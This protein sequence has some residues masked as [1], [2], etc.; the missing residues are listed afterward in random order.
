[1]NPEAVLPRLNQ[2]CTSK[3]SQMPRNLRLWATDDRH[4]V[5]DA[6]FATAKQVQDSQA[7]SVRERPAH[8]VN[9][10]GCRQG[11][12]RLSVCTGTQM[13]NVAYATTDRIVAY[14]KI[15]YRIGESPLTNRS[16]LGP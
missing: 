3:V 1:M 15:D 10:I 7:R 13:S 8:N 14:L 9:T 4:E 12:I 2:S 11:H 6:R 16:V 5:A